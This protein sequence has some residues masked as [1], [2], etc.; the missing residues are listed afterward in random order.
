M[1]TIIARKGHVSARG[2]TEKG[3]DVT[4]HV[5][6]DNGPATAFFEAAAPRLK[7]LLRTAPANGTIGLDLCFKNGRL[8]RTVGRVE[9]S[10]LAG[11]VVV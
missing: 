11:E 2:Y 4:G 9:A 5:R 3:G 7:N 8:C 1:S 6:G 10:E